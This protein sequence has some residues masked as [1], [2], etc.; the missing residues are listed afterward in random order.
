MSALRRIAV[1]ALAAA[2]AVGLAVPAAGA[3]AH[4]KADPLAGLSGLERQ[5]TSQML[6]M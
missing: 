4:E 1:A 2:T 5:A 3:P 6:G